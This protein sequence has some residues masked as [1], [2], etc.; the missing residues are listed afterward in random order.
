PARRGC[1]RR[2]SPGCSTWEHP[3][4]DETAALAKL[5]IAR[6]RDGS[7]CDA[8]EGVA[9][10][11]GG[12]LTGCRSLSGDSR[13]QSTLTDWIAEPDPSAAPLGP[14]VVDRPSCS[15]LDERARPMLDELVDLTTKRHRQCQRSESGTRRPRQQNNPNSMTEQRTAFQS[16]A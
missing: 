10:P 12:R 16:V 5:T 4:C 3:R 7:G 2:E 8:S 14:V 6:C 9:T 1:G 13:L 15:L 11:P